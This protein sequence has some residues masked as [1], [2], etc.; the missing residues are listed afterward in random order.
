LDM[1]R[2]ACTYD[3]KST[4]IAST[5]NR[6]GSGLI[7]QAALKDIFTRHSD[8][9][10][11]GI[12]QGTKLILTDDQ[13]T[14]LVKATFYQDL[15]KTQ[16][17]PYEK[18]FD[19]IISY[20]TNPD[21]RLVAWR[22]DKCSDRRNKLED[23]QTTFDEIENGVKDLAQYSNS[24]FKQDVNSMKKMKT[25]LAMLEKANELMRVE[26]DE[27]YYYEDDSLMVLGPI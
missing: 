13:L 7:S 10:G 5:T 2:M 18:E 23:I 4:I 6:I 8:R 16:S 26:L 3:I 27:I 19:E 20:G 24:K 25:K 1:F 22:S 9:L 21:Q 12:R 15:Y 14:G 11:W 17:T